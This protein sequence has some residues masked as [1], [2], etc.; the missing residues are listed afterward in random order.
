MASPD[1]DGEPSATRS[2]GPDPTDAV[3]SDAA[4]PRRWVHLPLVLG[5][6]AAVLVADQLSKWWA[7]ENLDTQT[8][9]LVW[10]L[11]LNL[12]F[13][14]GAAFSFGGGGG[15]GPYIGLAALAVVGVLLWTGRQFSSKFGAVA[16]GLVLGGALGNLADRAFRGDGL[17]DG[18]VIDFIDVQ[19]WPIFNVAD[20]GVVIGAI[21]L[22]IVGMRAPD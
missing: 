15:F 8:I 9:D 17:F 4:V 12:T 21:L 7:L 22:A 14:R 20:M 10:T 5:V 19:W 2:T 1:A 6:A 16:L 13:N 18:A 3:P 11:R